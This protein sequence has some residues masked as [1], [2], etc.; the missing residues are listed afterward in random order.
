MFLDESKAITIHR[1]FLWHW[2]FPHRLRACRAQC[3]FSSD[4][5]KFSQQTYEANFG[6]KPH[7]DIHKVAVADI[8]EFDVLCAGFPCQPFSIAGVSK[9]LSL[10]R[11]HG[12]E[13]EKQG[14]LF[15][16]IANIL[17][18]HKPAA[19]VLE[20]VKHLLRHDKAARFEI[21]YNTLTEALGY[22]RLFRRSSTRRASCRN[23]ASAFS[24]W[25]SESGDISSSRSFL[26]AVQ[27]SAPSS[28]RNPSQNTRSPI[29]SGITSRTML[30]NIARLAMALASDCSPPMTWRERSALATTKTAPKFSSRRAPE[31]TRVAFGSERSVVGSW[32]TRLTLRFQSLTPRSV[33]TVW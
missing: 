14:N 28:N 15:F 22:T 24:L 17:E 18:Y 9:K 5:D 11:K 29:I 4:W 25:V 1:S 16:E 12:F 27:S 26:A 7:G 33:S 20:N 30:P 19:F 8:P 10:G 3:V 32:A 2:R 31:K 23:T 21:I 6:E 13:D